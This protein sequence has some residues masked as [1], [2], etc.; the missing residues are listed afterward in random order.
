MIYVAK[1]VIPISKCEARQP[2]YLECRRDVM[3][4]NSGLSGF[5]GFEKSLPTRCRLFL[6]LSQRLLFS[7]I[8][9]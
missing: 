3:F 8:D 2:G 9:H 7:D 1:L 6:E 5:G 4:V